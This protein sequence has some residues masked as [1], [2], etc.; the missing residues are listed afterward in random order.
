MRVIAWV[1]AP[2]LALSLLAPSGAVC[3]AR[4][5]ISA[6]CC[7]ENCP[8]SP[9]A[10]GVGC[11]RLSANHADAAMANQARLAKHSAYTVARLAQ[12]RPMTAHSNLWNSPHP[13]AM[14]DPLS[15]L[16]SRQ[17]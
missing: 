1:L 4:A 5:A 8:A 14:F 17:I 9:H 7:G 11:C 2:L 10:S 15:L 12:P 3:S 13:A 6:K 16:C